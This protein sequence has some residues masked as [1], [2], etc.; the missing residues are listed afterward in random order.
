MANLRLRK[1]I[2]EFSDEKTLIDVEAGSLNQWSLPL[3]FHEYLELTISIYIYT[4]WN[5]FSNTVRLIPPFSVYIHT[6][7]LCWSK[8]NTPHTFKTHVFSAC[9]P[10]SISQDEEPPDDEFA[11]EDGV[12]FAGF[13]QIMQWMSDC[14]WADLQMLRQNH[15]LFLSISQGRIFWTCD[16]DFFCETPYFCSTW[17]RQWNGSV[18]AFLEDFPDK[19]NGSWVWWGSNQ[20]DDKQRIWKLDLEAIGAISTQQQRSSFWTR[21]VLPQDFRGVFR[22][23]SVP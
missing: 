11:L 7:H 18:A 5:I 16:V 6:Y 13:L 4:C 2:R 17:T 21:E 22:H 1:K 15:H 19:V 3:M 14:S 23:P 20:L 8:K 10:G 9:Q 12:D